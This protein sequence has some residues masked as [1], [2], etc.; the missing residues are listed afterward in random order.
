MDKQRI[1][2]TAV[3]GI[4]KQNALAKIENDGDVNCVYYD[5]ATGNRCAIGHLV[6]K[7]QAETLEN[8]LGG[9]N[10]QRVSEECPSYFTKYAFDPGQFVHKHFLEDLQAVHDQATDIPDFINSAKAF[11]AQ[12]NLEFKFA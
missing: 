11:A 2:D 8:S 7:N 9:T 3:A 10:A 12:H 1:F 4:I 6:T 5:E